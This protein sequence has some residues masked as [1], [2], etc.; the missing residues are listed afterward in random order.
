MH[1]CICWVR[2]GIAGDWV[3]APPGGGGGP[4]R[5]RVLP[6]YVR[7]ARSACRLP[8]SRC[9]AARVTDA[10][11]RPLRYDK[12]VPPRGGTFRAAVNP[13]RYGRLRAM[14]MRWTWLV[15]S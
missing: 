3:M 2:A 6:S 7:R 14:T 10:V 12:K 15:P 11:P 13:G 8:A 5:A 1:S 9:A 4:G